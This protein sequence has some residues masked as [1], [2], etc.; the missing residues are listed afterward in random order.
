[1]VFIIHSSKGVPVISIAC[2]LKI[3]WSVSFWAIFPSLPPIPGSIG[4][5]I[6]DACQCIQIPMWVLGMEL[7]FSSLHS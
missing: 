7:G 2:V 6:I 1:M 3:I 4:T 5:E